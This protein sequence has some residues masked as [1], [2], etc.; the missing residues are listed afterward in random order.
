MATATSTHS[1]S[2]PAE[3]AL[4]CVGLEAT[5]SSHAPMPRAEGAV[6]LALVDPER[7]AVL[8][9]CDEAS[10]AYDPDSF[11]LIFR[12]RGRNM[13]TMLLPIALLVAWGVLWGAVLEVSEPVRSL[14]TPLSDVFAPLLTTVAFLLVFRL[15]RAAVRFWDARAAAGKMV[16]SSRI[17]SADVAVACANAPG[18][19]NEFARWIGVFPVAV[20]N[21]LRPSHRTCARVAELGTLLDGSEIE[22]LLG[23]HTCAPLLVLTRLRQAAYRVPTEAA[24][25][26]A[27]AM[28][29]HV[30]RELVQSINALTAAWGALERINATPLPFVYVAHLR[31]LLVVYLAVSYLEALAAHGWA[32]LPGLVLSS[33]ALLGIEAAAIECERP[34]RRRPNHLL[35]GRFCHV[36]AENVAQTLADAAKPL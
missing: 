23:P 22:Q 7:I 10:T 3:V 24:V 5:S 12:I 2:L 26:G 35:L 33:W 36:I 4:A 8:K 21:F 34:F 15:S 19:R 29:A 6:Q 31:T 20:K 28:G 17:L 27:P 30:Y 13:R 16:E 32:A 9:A 11:W 25:G 1:R 18:L 14:V